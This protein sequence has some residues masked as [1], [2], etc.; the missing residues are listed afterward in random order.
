MSVEK[1][2][3]NEIMSELTKL[4]QRVAELEKS[5]AECKKLKKTLLQSEKRFKDITKNASEWIWELDLAGKYAY[6][7]PAVK[8]IL[9]YKPEEVL[10]IHIYDLFHPEDRKNLKKKIFRMF[11]KKQSFRKF[12][13]RCIHKNGRTVWLSTS[14]IPV[15]GDKWDLLGY[16]GVNIDITEQRQAMDSLAQSETRYRI[17]VE[18]LQEGIGIVDLDENIVFAN[19]AFCNIFGYPREKLTGMNLG[20]FISGDEFEKM[21]QETAK[22]KKNEASQYELRIKRKDDSFRDISIHAS[23]W[24]NEKG[25]CKGTI[26]VLL[27]IT[28][29]KQ[30]QEALQESEEKYRTMIEHSNDMIWKL[31]EQGNFTYYNK[32]AEEI[33]GYNL[34]EWLGKSFAPLLHPEDLPAIQKV[35]LET[36]K[37]NP[38][39]YEV[40]VYRKDRSIFVLSVNTVP[41][42]KSGKVVGTV[43]FGRDITEQKRAQEALQESEEKYRTMIEHSNDMIWTLNLEGNFTYVNKRAEQISGHK[44]DDGFGKHFATLIPPE[45]LPRI[46]KVFLETMSGKSQHYEVNVYKKGG[47]VFVL[48]VNTAP[49]FK[50]GKIVGT[51]SFGRDITEQ[52]RAQEALQESEEKYRTMIEHSNDM[53]WTLNL[54]GNFTYVN[55]RAEQISGHKLDDGFGKHFATLIPPE[56]LPRIQK[57]FLETMSGKSQHYEVNVYKKGGSVFV[58]SVNTAPLFKSG[59]IVGTVSFGRDITKQKQTQ[60]AL[61]KSEEKYKTFV[62]NVNVGIYRNTV[63]PK[64]KFIEANPA[65]IKMFGYESKDEFLSIDVADLYQNPEDRERFNEKMLA[66]GFVRDEEL[67]LKKKDGKPI[68]CSVVAV[69]VKDKQGKI[70]YYDGI[71]EDITKRKKVE[72]ELKTS[73]KKLKKILNGTINALA[74]TTEKRDPYT[75][76]HQQRVTQLACVI[77]REMG[78]SEERIEG[79]RMACMVHDIGKIYVAAEILNKPV[80]L[81]DIEMALIK[82]HCQIGYEILKTI[83]FPWPIAEVVLQHH[84]RMDGSGYPQG[85]KGKDILHEAKILAVVDVVEAMSSHRPYRSS[86]GVDLALNEIKENRGKLYDPEIVDVCLKLFTEKGFK[87]N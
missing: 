69:V 38:Q 58:L 4:R 73:Y 25:E 63:G 15:F 54:E 12:I 55:K 60:E 80:R 51:V 20:E 64:G 71:I 84:E 42:F 14:G 6:A 56:D 9:G 29:Q 35:F 3:D 67:Q 13:N 50:S 45:D 33:S 74:S 68:F 11:V 82:T 83:E 76:G 72:Q 46:Q 36:M 61:G 16:R 85:L 86:F 87:F 47:S 78:F 79:M 39:Q 23:P 22:R 32:R 48:S 75:A 81:T 10:K 5:E 37:G 19:S 70:K 30:V 18:T 26:G 34:R 59:K 62:N 2:T 41:L 65:V 21:R 31:D 8:A 1:K 53:I 7:S 57:V 40:R 49:L 43:S 66:N 52:K 44:L 28:E 17:L 27:D 24:L 77:A